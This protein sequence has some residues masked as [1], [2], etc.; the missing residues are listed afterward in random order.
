[1]LIMFWNSSFAKNYN[2]EGKESVWI[3]SS[4]A[5]EVGGWFWLIWVGEMGHS[6]PTH[7]GYF[8]ISFFFETFFREETG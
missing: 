4:F 3:R 6:L 5:N 2:F 7:K 1:M 8:L